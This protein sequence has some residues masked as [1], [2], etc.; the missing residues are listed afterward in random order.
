MRDISARFASF[1]WHVRDIDGHDMGQILDALA[2]AAA[3]KGRPSMIVAKTVKG[4]GVPFMENE[5]AWHKK[6]PSQ[7]EHAAAMEALGGAR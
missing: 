4:K 7:A 3:V 5:N 2:E 6:V 1:G